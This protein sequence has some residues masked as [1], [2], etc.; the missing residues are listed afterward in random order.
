M[1]A[2]QTGAEGGHH[3]LRLDGYAG[4]VE[5]WLTATAEEKADG[6]VWWAE[7]CVTRAGHAVSEAGG[8]SLV[9]LAVACGGGDRRALNLNHEFPGVCVV[10]NAPLARKGRRERRGGTGDRLTRPL[11]LPVP[12]CHYLCWI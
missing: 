11:A 12:M 2:L 8:G 4:A 6:G 10:A 5:G 7:L 9:G 3:G 1:V